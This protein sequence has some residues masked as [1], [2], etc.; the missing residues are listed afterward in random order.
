[1]THDGLSNA[2]VKCLI[3]FPATRHIHPRSIR[4]KPLPQVSFTCP[5]TTLS[6]PISLH[7]Q[8]PKTD[9]VKSHFHKPRYCAKGNLN[10]INKC[11]PSLLHLGKATTTQL[12]EDGILTYLLYYPVIVCRIAGISL[13]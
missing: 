10:K 11:P 7:T 13:T 8:P 3:I 12:P 1:M 6:T 5:L 2:R 4:N 9:R